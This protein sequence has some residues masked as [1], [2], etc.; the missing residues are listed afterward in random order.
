M[1]YSTTLYA[2]DL[3]ALRAA[4]GSRDAAL[5]ER[6]QALRSSADAQGVDPTR[7]PRIKVTRDSQII[8]NGQAVTWDE[9]QAIIRQPRWDGMHLYWYHERGHKQ[10]IWSERGSF[11]QAL[12]AALGGSRITAMMNCNDEQE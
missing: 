10:G 1:G 11:A 5:I 9:C 4:V 3:E 8:L 6:A 2:V 7:G 12:Y